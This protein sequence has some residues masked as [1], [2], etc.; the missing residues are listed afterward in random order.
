MSEEMLELLLSDPQLRPEG[1]WSAR[2]EE[3]TEH[4]MTANWYTSSALAS[5]RREVS[6]LKV[7]LAG[8]RQEVIDLTAE[9]EALRSAMGPDVLQTNFA[10]A[11]FVDHVREASQD[12][13][14]VREGSQAVP[15]G[16]LQ[17]LDIF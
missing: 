4:R 5:S 17:I 11:S 6:R 3:W 15:L 16:L 1:G 13:C 14:R 12:P 9:C 8:E 2:A 10:T 7:E